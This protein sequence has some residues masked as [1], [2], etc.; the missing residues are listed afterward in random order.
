MATPGPAA[1]P[2]ALLGDN[3]RIIDRAGAT[4]PDGRFGAPLQPQMALWHARCAQGSQ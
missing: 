3:Q 2:R 1:L 4:V